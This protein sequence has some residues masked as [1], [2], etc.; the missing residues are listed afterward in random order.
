M[1]VLCNVKPIPSSDYFKN[2]LHDPKLPLLERAC[3]DCAITTGFYIP[4]ADDL[5][6]ED[7]R[8]QDRILEGWFCH[9]HCNKACRGARNYV[10]SMNKRK[11]KS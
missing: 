6:K 10:T 8:T 4:I 9:N 11:E 2:K 3:H 5:L 7:R 1:R